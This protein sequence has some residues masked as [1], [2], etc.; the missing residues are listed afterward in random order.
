MQ[1]VEAAFKVLKAGSVSDADIS[2]GKALLKGKIL[3]ASENSGNVLE[4]IGI[5][6]LLNGVVV[7]GPVLADAVD[8]ISASEV[9]AAARKVASGKFSLAGF[10][11]LSNVPY[12]DQLK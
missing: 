5:Q 12:L 11:D 2:R 1:A 9:S 10:G 4:D 7:P 6:A 8:K 3:Q